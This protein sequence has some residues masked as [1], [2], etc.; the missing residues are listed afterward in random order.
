[1]PDECCPPDDEFYA[2]TPILEHFSAV[3]DLSAYRQLP[4]SWH[5]AIADV[6]SSTTAVEA[7]LYK[8][9]NVVG[10]AAIAAV[11]NVARPTPIPYV[12]GGDG[13]TLCVPERLLS[14][15]R[16]A[17]IDT[18]RMARDQ[19]GLDLRVGTVPIEEVTRAGFRVLVA[20]QRISRW[21]LQASFAGNGPAYAEQLIKDDEAGA[22][23]R[24]PDDELGEACDYSGLECRWREV[25]SSRGETIA[26]IVK[27]RPRSPEDQARVYRDVIEEIS[28]VYGTDEQCR[29][30][31]PA[32]LRLALS[33]AALRPEHRVRTYGRRL[34]ERL[35][36]ALGLRLQ[37]L[38]G[39]ALM[40]FAIE[41]GGVP[42]GRYKDDLAT[43]TDFR[44][45]DGVLREVLSGTAEQRRQLTELLERRRETGE[46]VYGIH[47]A[48]AA[49]V[50]CLIE[51]RIG[52]HFHFVDGA[53][54]GYALA[55]AQMKEQL[56]A[57]S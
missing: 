12:F 51:S 42:W 45:F 39:W 20:R 28:Q 29:P 33:S 8:A 3:T 13:A 56:A 11:R 1:M 14:A 4:R 5:L 44:K 24:I 52:A 54:G 6:R 21:L 41:P 55:A 2:S 22:E 15:T 48:P 35:R 50:T 27:A 17:L 31:Q 26:L 9:V 23:F 47:A 10:V 57:C 49:L 38:S 7:G 34:R 18:R 43:N 36:Y 30:V 25:R 37:I 32:A 19:F 53:Q 16:R 40:R 46:C